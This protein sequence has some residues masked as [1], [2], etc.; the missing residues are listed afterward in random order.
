VEDLEFIATIEVPE[1]KKVL[2][3]ADGCGH[4]VYRRVHV[5]RQKSNI[6]VYGSSCAQ[7]LFGQLLR[8]AR[9]SINPELPGW[10]GWVQSD[11][12]ALFKKL[13]KL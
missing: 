13:R 7:K 5:I 1:H 8:N 3:Q 4:S 2:C 10:A 6:G 9:P 12:R 11:A